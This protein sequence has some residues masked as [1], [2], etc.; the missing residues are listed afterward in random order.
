MKT[1]NIALAATAGAL[2]LLTSA[3]ATY[4]SPPP[5]AQP[6]PALLAVLNRHVTNDCNPQTAAVL[7]GMHLPADNIRGFNYGIYR[8]E[9]RDTIVRWDGWVYLK[10]QP[11][12]LVVTLDEDC[13][14]IQIYAREGAKLPGG[15]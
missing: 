11:G 5:V 3:C 15:R 14:P 2:T 8:D 4:I 6:D 7:T 9:Y 10:D 12:A 1:P 13:R